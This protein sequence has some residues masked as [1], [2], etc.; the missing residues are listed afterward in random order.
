MQR[1]Y[2]P[3]GGFVGSGQQTQAG[4][5]TLL[6]TRRGGNGGRR[7]RRSRSSSRGSSAPRRK[8]R[9]TGRKSRKLRRLVKGSAEARRYMARIRRMRGK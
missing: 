5:A 8:R 9:A 1:I 6:G 2:I 7:R 3:P 4:Q